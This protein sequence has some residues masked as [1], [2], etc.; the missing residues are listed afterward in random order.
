M[1]MFL[2]GLCFLVLA[3]AS[4]ATANYMD[5]EISKWKNMGYNDCLLTTRQLPNIPK[6]HEKMCKTLYEITR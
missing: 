1:K 4:L 3:V 5:N 6:V 2:P